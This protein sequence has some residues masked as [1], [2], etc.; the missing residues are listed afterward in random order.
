M[1]GRNLGTTAP[2]IV[3]VFSIHKERDFIRVLG[4]TFGERRRGMRYYAWSA[5]HMLKGGSVIREQPH[6]IDRQG[7]NTTGS[8]TYG[9]TTK[10]CSN[11]I[12]ALIDT[13]SL[14]AGCKQTRERVS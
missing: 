4:T 7:Y 8:L 9:S 12:T 2:T 1:T 14:A 11:R 5:R 10:A 6:P 3:I 13:I